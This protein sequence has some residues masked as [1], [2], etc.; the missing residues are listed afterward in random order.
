VRVRTVGG[1]PPGGAAESRDG[2]LLL[3]PLPPSPPPQCPVLLQPLPLPLPL[4][5]LPL[6][7]GAAAWR[8]AA[9]AATPGVLFEAQ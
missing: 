3:L 9:Q 6:P 2:L 8:P 5:L 1:W 4:P 7:P